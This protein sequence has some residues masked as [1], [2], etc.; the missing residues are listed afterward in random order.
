MVAVISMSGALGGVAFLSLFFGEAYFATWSERQEF[1]ELEY[2]FTVRNSGSYT[3]LRSWRIRKKLGFIAYIVCAYILKYYLDLALDVQAMWIF[4]KRG[5]VGFFYCNLLGVAL[6]LGWTGYEMYK[7]MRKEA[8]AVEAEEGTWQFPVQ[9]VL[10]IGLT[11]PV[12]GFHVLYLAILSIA[13]GKKHPFLFVSTVAEAILEASVSCMIQTY[14]VVVKTMDWSDKV[15]MYESII[16]SFFSI[17]HAFS[18]IDGYEGGAFLCKLPGIIRS[19]TEWRGVLAHI[20][21]IAE[22]TSRATSIALF[23]TVARKTGF[24]VLCVVDLTFLL[25]MTWIFQWRIA[26]AVYAREEDRRTFVLDNLVFGFVSCCCLMAPLFEKDCVLTMPVSLYYMWRF[27][28]LCGM[29]AYCAH[30][31]NYDMQAAQDLFSDDGLMVCGF[32][33]STVVMLFLCPI[34]RLFCTVRVLVEAPDGW[35][36]PFNDSQQALRNRILLLDDRVFDEDKMHVHDELVRENELIM[37]GIRMC[38]S[39]KPSCDEVRRICQAYRIK[40]PI[41]EAQ[42]LRA[43]VAIMVEDAIKALESTEHNLLELVARGYKPSEALQVGTKLMTGSLVSF[44]GPKEI[45][46]DP[47]LRGQVQSVGRLTVLQDFVVPHPLTNERGQKF[48]IEPETRDG[49]RGEGLYS[50]RPLRVRCL[51]SGSFLGFLPSWLYQAGVEKEPQLPFLLGIPDVGGWDAVPAEL[52]AKPA[53]GSKVADVKAEPSRSEVIQEHPATMISLSLCKDIVYPSATSFFKKVELLDTDGLS[54]KHLPYPTR[55]GKKAPLNWDTTGWR[56]LT[57]NGKAVERSDFENRRAQWEKTSKPANT[58]LVDNQKAETNKANENGTV[59]DNTEA[60][61]SENNESKA[62]KSENNENTSRST[63]ETPTAEKNRKGKNLDDDAAE[64]SDLEEHEISRG[65]EGSLRV[66]FK[67]VGLKNSP[68]KLLNYDDKVVITPCGP[69]ASVF[70]QPDAPV[71]LDKEPAINAS[72]GSG[73]AGSDAASGNGGGAAKEADKEEDKKAQE[74]TLVAMVGDEEKASPRGPTRQQLSRQAGRCGGSI[75]SG[76][77]DSSETKRGGTVFKL[78]KPSF[79]T[80]DDNDVYQWAAAQ[81]EEGRSSLMKRE[82]LAEKFKILTV[83]GYNARSKLKGVAGVLQRNDD[84][85]LRLLHALG[86]SINED[87]DIPVLYEGHNIPAYQ[88]VQTEIYLETVSRPQG[89]VSVFIRAEEKEFAKRQQLGVKKG[90]KGA[91]EPLLTEQLSGDKKETHEKHE[92]VSVLALDDF[93]QVKAVY[94][95]PRRIIEGLGLH[96]LHG[97]DAEKPVVKAKSLILVFRAAGRRQLFPEVTKMAVTNA[98]YIVPCLPNWEEICRHIDISGPWQVLKAGSMFKSKMSLCRRL[99]SLGWEKRHKDFASCALKLHRALNVAVYARP[100]DTPK[101]A[102]WQKVSTVADMEDAEVADDPERFRTPR[103]LACRKEGLFARFY[104]PDDENSQEFFT[105]VLSSQLEVLVTSWKG[106]P[107]TVKEEDHKMLRK[108]FRPEFELQA[109]LDAVRCQA[110][111]KQSSGGSCCPTGGRL[112]PTQRSQWNCNSCNA[113]FPK[114]TPCWKNALNHYLGPH[115]YLCEPCKLQEDGIY[116]VVHIPDTLEHLWSCMRPSSKDDETESDPKSIT[117]IQKAWASDTAVEDTKRRADTTLILSE[118]RSL[119]VQALDGW[120]AYIGD[121]EKKLDELVR[122]LWDCEP[123]GD[124]TIQLDMIDEDGK[125]ELLE[126]LDS[127]NQL[128]KP[129]RLKRKDNL[130]VLPHGFKLVLQK[131]QEEAL[132]KILKETEDDKKNEVS[133][134]FLRDNVF[135]PTG[136]KAPEQLAGSPADGASAEG[137]TAVAGQERPEPPRFNTKGKDAKIGSYYLNEYCKL[138]IDAMDDRVKST[139]PAGSCF[140]ELAQPQTEL[141]KRYE[142]AKKD[143]RGKLDKSLSEAWSAVD[144]DKQEGEM[145]LLADKLKEAKEAQAQ[146]QQEE[147]RRMEQAKQEAKEE[148]M[149]E[150]NDYILDLEEERDRLEEQRERDFQNMLY[151]SQR[152][153]ELESLQMMKKDEQEGQIG[154]FKDAIAA[155]EAKEKDFSKVMKEINNHAVALRATLSAGAGTG[156]TVSQAAEEM[157]NKI[158]AIIK[159]SSSPS[160]KK[161]AQKK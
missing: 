107:L 26:S 93:S 125:L 148:A 51:E 76:G 45:S 96:Q 67:W 9:E 31:L 134:E 37:N 17:G 6:A 61:K 87:V 33:V 3:V 139:I 160:P 36:Q 66:V 27:L 22:V 137:Q 10:I 47:A 158:E 145:K 99:L 115:Y 114:E 151:M 60:S 13:Y 102:Q 116:K 62:A 53:N 69:E 19:N 142:D 46:T 68:P 65:M 133:K 141:S 130:I 144:A 81:V 119:Y 34:I 84:L 126:I 5:D 77:N 30:R 16:V 15:A 161:K 97:K 147:M 52:P 122:M 64:A 72:N 118:Y 117:W 70:C 50:G 39:A 21:R 138:A 140:P 89:K 121:L 40:Y 38:S 146:A 78:E 32:L 154:A 74:H 109:I 155:Y 49:L 59:T 86:R 110:G 113:N 104:E 83:V 79:M 35:Q 159:E 8:D 73:T 55:K 85:H 105:E 94:A 100:E 98:Q 127:S 44:R 1:S 48:V 75:P 14:A 95:T 57:I 23:M 150:G 120:R 103:K 157:T 71:H 2:L 92:L 4:L 18:S 108:L 91:G 24:A 82:S 136:V 129:F 106:M 56:I 42:F 132:E 28:E 11:L 88:Q 54:V 149:A 63:E 153:D 123:R 143:A 152:I 112:V 12:A 101:T 29:A 7:M 135:F 156:A 20:F 25:G 90:I 43:K 41:W 124:N 131:E 128:T 80:E 58:V 111:P